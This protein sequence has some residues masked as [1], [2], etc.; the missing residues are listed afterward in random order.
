[1]KRFLPA[2]FS[3]AVVAAIGWYVYASSAATISNSLGTPFYVFTCA[4]NADTTIDLP[5]NDVLFLHTGIQ[6]DGTTASVAGD[7]VT[8]MNAYGA[9]G[10]TGTTMASNYSAGAKLNIQS[11]AAFTFRGGDTSW[12]TANGTRQVIVRANGHG[13]TIQIVKGSQFGSKQ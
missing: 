12:S 3:V 11:G 9:D 10:T 5:D 13:A 7:Y 2:F 1:M 8:V 4:T 6:S